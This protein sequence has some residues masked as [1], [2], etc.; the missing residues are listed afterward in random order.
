MENQE[1]RQYTAAD[2]A[3]TGYGVP[4]HNKVIV[5]RADELAEEHPSQLF[6]CTGGFGANANPN[7]RSVFAVSLTDGEFCRWY[8]GDVVG[9]LKPELLPDEARLAL[10]QIRPG[11]ARDVK[12]PEF[13]GYCFLEDGRYSAGVWLRDAKE[14]V[15]YMEM[16]APYQH[17]VLLCDR[18]DLAVAEMAGG[19]LLHPTPEELEAFRQDKAPEQSQGG[20]M[21]MT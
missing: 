21:K 19:K 17:R 10:S 1:N 13:S 11:G 3:E 7:G 6:F 8:R 18:G 16:Q 12:E 14:A 2:C 20:G 15:A 4:L 9:V 5:I